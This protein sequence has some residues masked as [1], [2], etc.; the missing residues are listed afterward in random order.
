[1]AIDDLYADLPIDTS[2]GAL[3]LPPMPAPPPPIP[4]PPTLGLSEQEQKKRKLLSLIALGLGAGM[5]NSPQSIGLMAGLHGNFQTQDLQ[6]KDKDRLAL[7]SWRNQV[8]LQERAD[9]DYQIAVHQH[10]VEGQR[11][12]QVL[13]TT[14]GN[15][16]KA[17]E[18][19]GSKDK[20]DALLEQYGNALAAQGFRGYDA[21]SLAKQ[22][23]RY[24]Q[25]SA[26][27]R[28][29]A[30]FDKLLSNPITQET[31]KNDPTLLAK[32]VVQF[33]AN[34]D[35]VPE[36]Y[37]LADFAKLAG[38]PILT[39]PDSGQ[40][41]VA[42]KDLKD[43]KLGTPFQETLGVSLTKFRADNHREPTPREK[44]AL[45]EQAVVASKEKPP[46]V[47]VTGPGA[48]GTDPE[49]IADAIIA[50]DQ[51]PTLQGLYRFGGP[52]RSALA[53]KGFD[54]SGAQTDWTATQKHVATMNGAQQ[55]RLTQA[56]NAL[57]DMLDSVDSLASEWKGGRFAILNR[58]NL[59]AAKGGAYGPKAASIATRL[60]AQIADVVADL[61]NVYM[62]GNSPTDHA[63]ALAGKSL[64]AE[65]NEQVLKDMTALARKNVKIRLNSIKNTGVSG[66]SADNPYAAPAAAEPS[67]IE[68]WGRDASGKLV[69]R[70]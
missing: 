60:D 42:P 28:A 31:L 65:W 63:L 37:T 22:G 55:L 16:S 69:R 39:D 53:K 13:T 27:Q 21:N 66:A 25:P 12:G 4:P 47:N 18:G 24:V 61:G 52:V 70:P 9:R 10:V 45:V 17:L 58:A 41:M 7:E 8:A 48:A 26:E 54:L 5:G 51:P 38:R 44:Q 46:T 23:Y 3:G 33:D 6:Q 1:M 32:S 59:A 49:A 62:G 50:G 64:K 30:H 29:G 2:P 67:G 40:P 35:G 34:G 36:S 14:L 20:A 11:R 19:A 15:L 43:T 56:V 57:P 68:E